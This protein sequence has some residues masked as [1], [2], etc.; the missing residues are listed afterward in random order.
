MDIEAIQN[1]LNLHFQQPDLLKQALTHRSFV[2]ERFDEMIEDNERLEYLGDSILGFLTADMLFRRFPNMPEGE[3]TRLRS[4]LVR[5]EALAQLATD[6]QLGDALIIGKGEAASGG[7]ENLNNLC[8]AFEALI[9]A[10]FLDQGLEAVKEF[11]I[12]RLTELQKDVMEAALNKDP[13]SRFQEWAQARYSVTPS[14]HTIDAQG[15]EHEKTFTVRAF[16][17]EQIIAEGQGRNKRAAAQDAARNALIKRD[18][19]QLK[20]NPSVIHSSKDIATQ[21]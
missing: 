13:R 19:G 4:A 20:I 12:P 16:M 8:G 2:N 9:G 21:D 10:L 18:S 17:G 7:R 3:M 11:V 15:P 14:Y 6:C 5:T 1:T